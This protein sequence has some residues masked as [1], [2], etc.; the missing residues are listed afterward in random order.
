[1]RDLFAPCQDTRAPLER[2]DRRRRCRSPDRRIRRRAPG[3]RAYAARPRRAGPPADAST[4]PFE[5]RAAGMVDDFASGFT[6]RCTANG[7]PPSWGSRSASASPSASSRGWWTT[8]PRTRRRWF[9]LPVH[10][11]NLYR[12]TEGVHV[13]TGIIAIPLALGQVLGRVS[14]PVFLP[15]GPASVAHALERLSLIPLVGGALFELATGVANITYWY[16]PMPFNFTTAHFYVAWIAIGGLIVHIGAKFTLTRDVVSGRRS[17]EATPAVGATLR[18]RAGAATPMVQASAEQ[19]SGRGLS[20]RGLLATVGAAAGVLFV[21]VAGETLAPLR[22]LALLAPRN[23][24]IGPQ[25]LPVNRTAAGANVIVEALSPDYRLIV[26][27]NCRRPRS[28]TLDELRSLP[29]RSAGLPI[30][31]VE[32]WS[33]AAE[34]AR[35][36]LADPA[37]DGRG[38]GIV[39]QSRSSR[40]SPRSVSTRTPSSIPSTPPIPTPCLRSSSTGRRSTS[41][42]GSPCA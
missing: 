1:M 17:G 21:T 25:S 35:Y 11:V 5:E 31:C 39:S 40:S 22:K 24:V 33:A 38:P 42:T 19:S 14:Q 30:S 20:R 2:S 27:G 12:V 8:W 7:S 29:Q 18:P 26:D 3:G 13:L 36:F 41:T 10:P 34:L 28:F 9:H 23:P 16:S 4:A 6:A 15:A 37:G 32:G